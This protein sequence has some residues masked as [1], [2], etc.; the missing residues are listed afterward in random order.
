MAQGSSRFKDVVQQPKG[1]WGAR[2]YERHAWLRLASFADD[3]AAAR[4][5]DVAALR[6][7]VRRRGCSVLDKLMQ[8]M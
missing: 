1:R 3:E 2:I 5:Y 6:Y 7:D 8:I 4:A